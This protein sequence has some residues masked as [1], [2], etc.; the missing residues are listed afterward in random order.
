MTYRYCPHCQQQ[1]PDTAQFCP[2]CGQTY[3]GSLTGRLS[4]ESMLDSRY[5]IVRLVGQGGM[6]A[7][8]QA[9]DTRIRGRICAVKEMGIHSLPPHERPSA[10]QNFEQ[11]AQMLAR[12]RHPCLP[13]VHDFFHDGQNGR[14]YLVMDFVE[15]QT[16]EAILKQQ[17]SLP[18]EVVRDWG[19]Q[20][21]DVL[22]YLHQQT[23]PIIFRDLKPGNIMLDQ[24]GQIKLIDFGIARFF[25]PAQTKDTQVIGTPGFAAPEQY[26]QGQTDARSDIYG[27]GVTFL[28]LLTGYDPAQNPFALPE[29]RQLNP[30]VSP[31]MSTIIQRATE[32]K[33]E[34]RWQSTA[35]LQQAITTGRL[36]PIQEPSSGSRQ[37]IGWLAG[38]FALIALLGFGGW[39]VF[40]RS[41]DPAPISPTRAVDE[42]AVTRVVVVTSTPDPSM[43]APVIEPVSD[44]PTPTAASIPSP[45][46]VAQ[47]S[48]TPVPPTNTPRPTETARAASQGGGRIVFQSNRD[49]DFEIY[50]I[51]VDG[52]DL[53]QLTNNNVD[54]KFPAV[55]PDGS[56]IAYQV[57]TGQ[58]E[59]WEIY[60]MDIDGRN[61]TRLTNTGG[62]NRLPTWSPDGRQIA[63]LSDRSGQLTLHV[64]DANGQNV[65]QIGVTGERDGRVSWSVN[66]RLVFNTGGDASRSWRIVAVD[67]DGR[68]YQSL[69]G[70]GNWSPEWSP[71][72][73]SIVFISS[74]IGGDTNPG[75][76]LMD[77]DGSNQRL[78]FDSPDY[79][80][81]ASWSGDGQ[82][83]LFTRDSAGQASIY[84]I[85]A[86][87]GQP[88]L[89][90]NRGSYPA[91][92]NGR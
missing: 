3:S 9:V 80:W 6:G 68:N 31:Q 32:M 14:Y 20:L 33:P 74:R 28:A 7:V 55:S 72:G 11:E 84:M 90:T 59:R 35:E 70:N 18:E 37:W 41:E 86:T 64:M 77:A 69:A 10:V 81:G 89:I 91:W 56:R 8:Y 27:L 49:G 47:P 26:G 54:D 23:P 57:W 5:L 50:S 75:I 76:F 45:E 19:A 88:V 66:N 40:G 16:L 15:G 42:V 34:Q 51:N 13:Q 12:L 44:P 46:P 79:E 52:T 4:P 63:F 24:S 17:G 71:D 85:P 29:A 73:R 22:H 39:A 60:V 78:L 65:R 58:G 61:Q 92:V 30:T 25:K 83:I 1:I 38:F 87:G 2:Y 82:H 62:W 67:P 21:C 36:S 53:R 43:A 48:D